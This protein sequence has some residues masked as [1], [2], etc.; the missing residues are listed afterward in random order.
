MR[1]NTYSARGKVVGTAT[2]EDRS[3]PGQRCILYNV[4]GG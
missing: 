1:I 4:K 3:R 2:R